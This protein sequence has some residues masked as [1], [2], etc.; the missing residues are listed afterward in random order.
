MAPLDP[1]NPLSPP[2]SHRPAGEA[3]ERP[4]TAADLSLGASSVPPVLTAP[5][6]ASGLWHPLGRRWL[7]A[8]FIALCGAGLVRAALWHLIPPPYV[9]PLPLPLRPPP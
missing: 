4:P 7:L 8:L 1:I 2:R 5:P 9:S 3:G 6:T